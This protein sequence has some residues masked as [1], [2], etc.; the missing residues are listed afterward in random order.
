MIENC[1]ACFCLLALVASLGVSPVYGEESAPRW[2]CT[3]QEVLEPGGCELSMRSAAPVIAVHSS[4]SGS[5]N[6]LTVALRG[7]AA[8][9][10]TFSQEVDGAVYHAELADLNADGWPEVYVYVSAAG[11]GSYGSLVAYAVNGGKS[12]SAIYL[13][14]L[15]DIPGATEGYMGH[16]EF[17]VVENRLV[18]RFPL[19]RKG[20]VNAQPTGG[21]RQLQYRLAPGEA[22]WVLEVDKVSS[23]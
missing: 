17:A 5:L 10:S 14:P 16:D 2:S 23:Y 3:A 13:P 8:D 6:T 21:T 7:A 15:V 12:L 9:N 20:D 11:S 4:G 18:Q 1:R 19:Y 22:G